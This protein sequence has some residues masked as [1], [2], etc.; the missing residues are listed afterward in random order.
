MNIAECTH[1][2]AISRR[3]VGVRV[4][5][6]QGLLRDAASHANRLS[7]L[8]RDRGGGED[9]VEMIHGGDH[10]REVRGLPREEQGGRLEHLVSRACEP[11][12]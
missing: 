9:F 2:N 12:Q 10:L 11:S 6:V 5:A 4:V 3:H 8:G 1:S 7:V